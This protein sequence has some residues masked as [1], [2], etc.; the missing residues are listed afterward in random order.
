MLRSCQLQLNHSSFFSTP[1]APANMP[2]A[3]EHAGIGSSA[4]S[5][6]LLR[7]WKIAPDR[8]SEQH[9]HR[10]RWVENSKFSKDPQSSEEEVQTASPAVSYKANG[11][12]TSPSHSQLRAAARPPSAA[13]SPSRSRS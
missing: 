13:L 6:R 10:R 1:D 12:A 2:G 5:T 7:Q 11:R 9:I 3:G 8:S 4:G